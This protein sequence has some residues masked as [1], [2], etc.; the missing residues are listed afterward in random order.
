MVAKHDFEPFKHCGTRE[1]WWGVGRVDLVKLAKHFLVDIPTGARLF[2]ILWS[3][4][5]ACGYNDELSLSMC[6]LRL[7][8]MDGNFQLME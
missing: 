4:C 2:L 3:F 1:A 8:R 5:K 6:F 7:A